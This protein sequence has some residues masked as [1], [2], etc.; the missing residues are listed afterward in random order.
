MQRSTAIRINIHRTASLFCDKKCL[1]TRFEDIAVTINRKR[2]AWCAPA[3]T[4]ANDAGLE[5]L[6]L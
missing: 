3:I 4:A 6:L 1:I 5:A 2:V